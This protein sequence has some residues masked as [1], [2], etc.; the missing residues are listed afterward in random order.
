MKTLDVTVSHPPLHIL[1]FQHLFLLARDLD[2]P[3]MA[4]TWW[5]KTR[6]G[7]VESGFILTDSIS[8]IFEIQF[9]HL[10]QIQFELEQMNWLAC[11]T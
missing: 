3:D 4:C 11:S 6:K 9:R 1:T 7:T 10:K 2:L 5:V 8:L